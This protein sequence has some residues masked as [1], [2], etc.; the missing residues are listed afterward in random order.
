VIEIGERPLTLADV[1]A[2]AR[3]HVTVRLA[4]GAR[5]GFDGMSNVM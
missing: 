5:V 1:A 4:P 2:V 3:D